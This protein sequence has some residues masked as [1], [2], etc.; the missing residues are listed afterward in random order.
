[1]PLYKFVYQYIY[2]QPDYNSTYKYLASWTI[3][4]AINRGQALP[5][6]P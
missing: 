5:G 6:W 1:M 3:I 2:N 4:M